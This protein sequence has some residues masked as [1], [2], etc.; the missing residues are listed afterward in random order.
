[1]LTSLFSMKIFHYPVEA[2]LQPDSL[3]TMKGDKSREK[4][5][6]KPSISG[7]VHD[8]QAH[9]HVQMKGVDIRKYINNLVLKG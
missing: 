5:A 6:F 3:P 4:K 2:S 9:T 8:F 7:G 1:M